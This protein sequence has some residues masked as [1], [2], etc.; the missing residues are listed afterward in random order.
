MSYKLFGK[1]LFENNRNRSKVRLLKKKSLF[2]L[3]FG[4]EQRFSKIDDLKPT[5]KQQEIGELYLCN[6]QNKKSKKGFL[7]CIKNPKIV[8][9]KKF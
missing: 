4:F 1:K 8:Q 5:K 7:G 6:I 2:F 9:I 3:F